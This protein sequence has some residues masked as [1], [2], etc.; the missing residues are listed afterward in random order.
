MKKLKTF[1][2]LRNILVVFSWISF[3]GGLL[4]ENLTLSILFQT[5]TRILS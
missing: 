3:F 5:I 1:F 2:K 4:I